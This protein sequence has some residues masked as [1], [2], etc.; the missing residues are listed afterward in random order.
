MIKTYSVTL[1]TDFTITIDT[2]I[3]EN[4]F[5]DIGIDRKLDESDFMQYAADIAETY[6]DKQH[7]EI[8]DG[9]VEEFK[10]AD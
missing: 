6:I 3:V 4:Y 7:G 10:E 8:V 5:K 1:T 9:Y 2:K